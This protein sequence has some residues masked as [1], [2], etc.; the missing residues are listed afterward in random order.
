MKSYFIMQ[1]QNYINYIEVSVYQWG[2]KDKILKNT[3]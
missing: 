3:T 1:K 2:P